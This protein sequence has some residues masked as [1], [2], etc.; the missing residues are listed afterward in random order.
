[1]QADGRGGDWQK[2]EQQ[3]DGHRGAPYSASATRSLQHVGAD[4]DAGHR[5]ASART[6]SG[7]GVP[8]PLCRHAHQNQLSSQQR[9]IH[10][11]TEYVDVRELLEVAGWA[12]KRN[13][14]PIVT[15]PRDR[16]CRAVPDN[17]HPAARW[18][19]YP[20]NLRRATVR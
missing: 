5:P 17:A 16:V 12:E 10:T 15:Y 13:E 2:G 4:F 19:R 3:S 7:E 1:M 6:R 9:L 20:G 14:H 8:E 18:A 11:A